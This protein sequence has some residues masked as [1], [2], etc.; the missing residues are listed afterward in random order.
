MS[1]RF[2]EDLETVRRRELRESQ[3]YGD[4]MKT[5]GLYGP[6]RP[7]YDIETNVETG[8]FGFKEENMAITTKQ[9]NENKFY[10]GSNQVLSNNW[11]HATVEEALNRAENLINE[12]T[13]EVFI[14]KI[15]KVV[16]KR[17]EPVEVVDVE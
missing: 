3:R 9:L 6:Y 13:K 1:K 12:K 8:P 5:G 16:R 10:V 4:W 17:R 11:G 7:C 15:I 2:D 14:V